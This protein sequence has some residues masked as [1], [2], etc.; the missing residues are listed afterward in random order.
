MPEHLAVVVRPAVDPLH[1]IAD[2]AAIITAAVALGA[3][4]L[5][6]LRRLRQRQRLEK[7]LKAERPEHRGKG[8]TGAR[9]VL[10]LM[11]ALGMSEGDVLNAAFRSK[12][13]KRLT[14]ADPESGRAT[15]ILLRFEDRGTA[16]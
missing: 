7:Y 10:H 4:F 15:A 1:T 8:D 16:N 5:L 6:W 12:K 9:T 3:S 11:A 14:A 2:A 13:V